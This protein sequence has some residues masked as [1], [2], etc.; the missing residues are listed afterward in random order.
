MH[1]AL[2]GRSGDSPD[3][4]DWNIMAAP[5][6]VARPAQNDL[7]PLSGG[8]WE[9][10]TGGGARPGAGHRVRSTPL[11]ASPLDRGEECEQL[12][13]VPLPGEEA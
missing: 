13:P 11:P 12:P 10:V 6:G 2:R 5:V 3:I 7:L 8:G 1:G 9:G 4:P